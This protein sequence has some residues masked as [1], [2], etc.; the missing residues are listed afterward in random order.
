MKFSLLLAQAKRNREE[1]KKELEVAEKEREKIEIKASE[2]EL[3][4][5]NLEELISSLKV[6]AVSVGCLIMCVGGAGC[7]CQGNGVALKAGRDE[8]KGITIS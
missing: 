2:L 5:K 1:T 7:G 6:H 8:T 4:Q 3:Q